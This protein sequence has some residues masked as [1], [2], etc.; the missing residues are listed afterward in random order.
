MARAGD[1]KG[2]EAAI[3]E[4]LAV[5][6]DNYSVRQLKAVACVRAGR[7]DEARAVFGPVTTSG[8][9]LEQ[10]LT[11]T[12]RVYVNNSIAEEICAATRTLWAETA[13]G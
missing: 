11:F 3:D 9:P 4:A 10:V 12:R 5:L 6:A 7:E 1:W 2:A 13:R 8:L